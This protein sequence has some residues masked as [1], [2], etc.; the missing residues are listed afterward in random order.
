M[1][2]TLI[3]DLKAQTLPKTVL[4]PPPTSTPSPV[5]SPWGVARE[6]CCQH[7]IPQHFCPVEELSVFVTPS[8]FR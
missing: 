2:F 1:V 5:P 7:A 3:V 4:P 6:S 8:S